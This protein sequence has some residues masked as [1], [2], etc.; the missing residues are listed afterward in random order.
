MLFPPGDPASELMRIQL[1]VQTTS[2]SVLKGF[3]HLLHGIQGMTTCIP[4][5]CSACVANHTEWWRTNSSLDKPCRPKQHH[6]SNHALKVSFNL[7]AL[8]SL[9]AG[10]HQACNYH[11]MIL[12]SACWDVCQN[13]QSKPVQRGRCWLNDAC[14]S[15]SLACTGWNNIH[16]LASAHWDICWNVL[17]GP[18]V[19]QR[20]SFCMT[21]IFFKSLA[22]KH[23]TGCVGCIYD[24]SEGWRNVHLFWACVWQPK[25]MNSLTSDEGV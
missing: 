6:N 23:S 3:K 25:G 4:C 11:I 24:A 1:S 13:C 20:G 8:N 21:S 14:S 12:L 19:M 9:L 10:W 17:G 16:R 18:S 5:H 22:E 2:G 15:Y 7:Y